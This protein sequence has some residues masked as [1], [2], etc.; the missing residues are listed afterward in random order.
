MIMIMPNGG[1]DI[2]AVDHDCGSGGNRV[3]DHSDIIPLTHQQCFSLSS[4]KLP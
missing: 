4:H 2:D 1:Y 3:P